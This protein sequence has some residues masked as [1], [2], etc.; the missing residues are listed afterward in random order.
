MR[1]EIMSVT[2]KMALAWMEKSVCKNRSLRTGM[3]MKY[4]GDMLEGRWVLN[5]ETIKISSTGQVLDGQHRLWA[6]I[7]SGCIVQMAVAFEEDHEKA[8]EIQA[9]VDSGVARTSAD[10]LSIM[11]IDHSRVVA[12]AVR[13]SVVY[14]RWAESDREFSLNTIFRGTKGKVSNIQV[15]NEYLRDRNRFDV[16]AAYARPKKILGVSASVIAFFHVALA[17]LYVQHF[18]AFIDGLDTGEDLSK[19]HPTLALKKFFERIVA[20][21]NGIRGGA[22]LGWP[23]QIIAVN[24]TFQTICEGKAIK[25][26]RIDAGKFDGVYGVRPHWRL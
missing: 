24:K 2:P 1:I 7:E 13:I 22:T 16:A 17:D 4:A 23:M 18:E 8:G 19:D 25:L 26:L 3:V 11:G 14:R 5:G 20:S 21:R 12:P 15:K 9:T 6:V 10:A